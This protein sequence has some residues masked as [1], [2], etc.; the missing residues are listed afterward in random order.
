M[1]KQAILHPVRVLDCGGSGSWAGVIAGVD[2]VRNDCPRN[3]PCVANMSL[4]GGATP[5]VNQ[6]VANAVDSGV[7]FVV[8]AGNANTDACTVSPAGEPKAI[9]VAAIDDTDK[10]AWF[11]NWGGCVDIFAPGV[12]IMGA[13]IGSPTAVRTIDGTSMASPHVAG[14]AALYLS[15]NPGATPAQVEANIE[16]SASIDCVGDP[17]GSPNMMLFSDMS[18]GNYYCNNQPQSCKGLCGSG[19]AGCFCDP[20]CEIYNDCCADYAQVCK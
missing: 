3:R 7:T 11:S 1:A 15:S 16:G 19:G 20:S 10:R 18:Q 14:A 12:S 4:G 5:A 9:T 2:F 8:A 17:Q 6:A 13:S